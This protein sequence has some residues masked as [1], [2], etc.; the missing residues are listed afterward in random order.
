MTE[1]GLGHGSWVAAGAPVLEMSS[2]RGCAE[3]G[4]RAVV[5]PAPEG[6]LLRAAVRAGPSKAKDISHVLCVPLSSA[7]YPPLPAKD[8]CTWEQEGQLI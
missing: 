3:P 8:L 6:Q 5:F 4:G 1:E 2:T 7:R